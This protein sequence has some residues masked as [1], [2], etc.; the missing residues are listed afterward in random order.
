MPFGDAHVEVREVL[1]EPALQHG[2]DDVLGGEVSGVDEIYALLISLDELVVLD[3]GGD[4]GVAALG[5]GQRQ[6]ARAGAAADAEAAHGL[7]R[8][9]VAQ[10][11]CAE[12][13]LDVAQEGRELH[14]LGHL[15]DAADAVVSVEYAYDAAAERR[16]ERVVHAALGRVE[17]RVHADCGHAALDYGHELAR[18]GVAVRHGLEALKGQ[19]M[20]RDYELGAHVLRLG[21]DLVGDVERGEHAAH[22]PVGAPGEVADVI[23]VHLQRDGRAEGQFFKYSAYF[24][25]LRLLSKRKQA[26]ERL[27]QFKGVAPLLLRALYAV[28]SALH[29]GYPRVQPAREQRVTRRAQ[30]VLGEERALAPGAGGDN[31]IQPLALGGEDGGVYRVP[32]HA[33]P[34]AEFVYL[35]LRLEHEVRAGERP[36]GASE[37]ALD[38]LAAHAGDDDRVSLLRAGEGQAIAELKTYGVL[39]AV[40]RGGGPGAGERAGTDI[41]RGDARGLFVLQQPNGEAAVVRAHVHG[42]AALPREAGGR[43]KSRCEFYLVHWILKKPAS[44]GFSFQHI[45]RYALRSARNWSGSTS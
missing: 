27:A 4:E 11:V 31:D 8:S 38:G 2:D 1:V 12:A 35:G 16:R 5:E 28:D 43:E 37:Y 17:I 15:A 23:E 24:C 40:F 30:R 45:A 41:R 44:A 32:R 22:F 33:Q 6:V 42:E 25:H 29:A 10:A 3:V 13:V 19:R 34:D 9:G 18:C 14:R 26:L 7:A 36:G 21:D 39:Q 20:V